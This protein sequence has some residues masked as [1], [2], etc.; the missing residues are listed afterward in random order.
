VLFGA[1]SSANDTPIKPALPGIIGE[2]DRGI[3]ESLMPPWN[4]IG[5]V[6]ISG[7]PRTSLPEGVLPGC[8][9]IATGRPAAVS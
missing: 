6:N 2:D 3:V 1:V 7:Y 9:I 4:A 5:R 8:R